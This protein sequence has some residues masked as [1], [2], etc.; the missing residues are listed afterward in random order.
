MAAP[1]EDNSL[2][3]QEDKITTDTETVTVA[4]K[5]C[6]TYKGGYLFLTTG[7]TATIGDAD[8]RNKVGTKTFTGEG[9]YIFTISK[10]ALK[11]GETLQPHLYI[12]DSDNDKTNYKY[13]EALTIQKAGGT[14]TKKA[15]TEIV[16]YNVTADRKDVWVSAGLRQLPDGN[17][18][19]LY[20]RR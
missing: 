12:Y 3:I 14:V 2:A 15:K 9:T 7:S 11:A 10:G 8:S 16:T 1:L 20:I 5:G 13:G 17:A 19:T 6:S 4:V 18:E